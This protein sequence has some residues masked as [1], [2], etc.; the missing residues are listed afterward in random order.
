LL[1]SKAEREI[2]ELVSG[3][4][5][6]IRPQVARSRRGHFPE[7]ESFDQDARKF[8]LRRAVR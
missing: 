7:D 2:R 5:G 1:E 3:K 6:G 4:P 8:R